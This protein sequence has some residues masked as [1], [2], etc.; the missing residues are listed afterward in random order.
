VGVIRGVHLVGFIA[1]CAWLF[2]HILMLIGF[3][4]RAV[5]IVEWAFAYLT[6]RRAARLITG[7]PAAHLNPPDLRESSASAARSDALPPN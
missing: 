1:W 5:V 7:H 4:N 3:R 6:N 2:I